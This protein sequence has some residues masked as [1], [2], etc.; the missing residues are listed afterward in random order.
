[1]AL[2]KTAGGW[3]KLSVVFHGVRYP[4]G[5]TDFEAVRLDR[6]SS[7]VAARKCCVIVSFFSFRLALRTLRLGRSCLSFF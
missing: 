4:I 1:M 5:L 7:S 2:D 6:L 3:I